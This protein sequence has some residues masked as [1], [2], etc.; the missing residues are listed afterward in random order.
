MSKPFNIH[1]WQ[2][3]QKQQRLDEQYYVTVNRG[4]KMGKSLVT[5]AESDYEEPRVFSNYGEAE[6]YIKRVKSSGA[7]PGQIASYWVSDENMNKIEDPVVAKGDGLEITQDEMERLH[8]NGRVRLKDGSLLVFPSKPLNVKEQTYSGFTRNPEDSASE[9]FEPAGVVAQFKEE[10]R[11]LFGKFKNSLKNP[12]F[13]KGVAQ[14]MINWK[15]LLRSQLEEDDIDEASATGTG[16]SF[17]A[18]AGEAYATPYAFKKKNKRK[19]D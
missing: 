5:S 9:P 2:A 8:R 19:K 12:E 18:G 14:I 11:A 6:K 1:D 7:T 17:Q 16:A 13:I 4:P 3:K 15:S 10:L